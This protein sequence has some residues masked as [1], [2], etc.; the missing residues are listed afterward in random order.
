MV[1]DRT[2]G[3]HTFGQL[4]PVLGERGQHSLVQRE[5]WLV[6]VDRRLPHGGGRRV[7]R[8]AEGTVEASA[9][10]AARARV[11]GAPVLETTPPVKFRNIAFDGFTNRYRRQH[12][13]L[14]SWREF[15]QRGDPT[16][17]D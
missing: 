15:C 16:I 13:P 4:V 14:R 8:E 6:N 1:F 12:P 9:L 2:L 17:L 10:R 5:Q 11:D 7:G 3:V